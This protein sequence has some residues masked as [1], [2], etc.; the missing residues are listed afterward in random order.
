MGLRGRNAKLPSQFV[1]LSVLQLP[2]LFTWFSWLQGDRA[3]DL[4]NSLIPQIVSCLTGACCRNLTGNFSHAI[5][6]NLRVLKTG[7]IKAKGL[8]RVELLVK[9]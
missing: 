5:V 7:S 6:L 8:Y 3:T 1:P 2:S 9:N 4:C